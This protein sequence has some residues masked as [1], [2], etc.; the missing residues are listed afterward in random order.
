MA[1]TVPSAAT[2]K[3][4]F[5]RFAAVD[6]A[7]VDA[8]IV[9]AQRNVD[10]SWTEGDYPMGLMLM[11]AHLMT[12]EGLGTGTEAEIASE[13]VGDYR[14]IRSGSLSLER[15]DNGGASASGLLGSTS[16]GRRFKALAAQNVGG[17]RVSPTGS[18]PQVG[19]P[20]YPY[21]PVG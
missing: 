3:A 18:V 16:Y 2:L 13:G 5:P 7:T 1:Y 11:A 14:S 15:F 6:D 10:E 4:R 21:W 8:L 9:E 19:W 17:P 12:L 20:H